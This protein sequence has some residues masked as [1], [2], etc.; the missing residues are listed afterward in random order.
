MLLRLLSGSIVSDSLQPHG[1]QPARF[2][3]PWD[4]SGENTGVGCCFLLQGIFLTQGSNLGRLC[5]LHW[6]LIIHSGATG[7]PY[8]IIRVC[9]CVCN[10]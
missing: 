8:K 5:L 1:L 7:E 9:V 4:F 3:Y 10:R 2:F 6:Q